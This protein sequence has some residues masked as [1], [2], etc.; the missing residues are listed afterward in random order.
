MPT[1]SILSHA[2]REIEPHIQEILA[3]EDSI[4]KHN[5]IVFLLNDVSADVIAELQSDL[6]RLA[7]QPTILDRSEDVDIA[8]QEIL[9]ARFS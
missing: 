9:A 8:A 4:W 5:I 2:G 7:N 1:A 6:E 3:G